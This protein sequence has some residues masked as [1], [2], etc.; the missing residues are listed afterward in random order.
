MN[1]DG[2]LPDVD[3]CGSHFMTSDPP[4]EIDQRHRWAAGVECSALF[5][6][7]NIASYRSNRTMVHR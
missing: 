1:V 7:S 6:T 4:H 3:S 2:A 5:Q